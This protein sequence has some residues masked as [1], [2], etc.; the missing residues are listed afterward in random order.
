MYFIEGVGPNWYMDSP[1]SPGYVHCFQN[2]TFFYKNMLKSWYEFEDCPCGY[3]YPMS[4]ENITDN[5]YKLFKTDSQLIIDFAEESDI[6]VSICG[7]D[8]KMFYT[9]HFTDRQIIIP[10]ENFPKGIYLIKILNKNKK[11]N[12]INKIIL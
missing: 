6:V 8:G 5:G 11:I 3:E 12:S 10:A 2:R 4:V 1:K 7:I 9:N